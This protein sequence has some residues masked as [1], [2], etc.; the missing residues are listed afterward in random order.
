M[1][2][3]SVR[4]Q[5]LDAAARRVAEGGLEELT[6]DQ[7]AADAGVSK[8]GLLYH[9]PTKADLIEA[10]IR[11]VLRRF[12][13]TVERASAGS[14]APGTWTRAYI[15]ATFDAEVSRPALATALLAS[16]EVGT[17]L[18]RT[19]ARTFA[20][21]QRSLVADGIDAGTAATIRFAC[22]GWWTLSSLTGDGDDDAELLRARLH[23]LADEAVSSRWTG[24]GAR[25]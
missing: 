7:V 17:D 15:D 20:D 8:G 5:L 22:D 2:R 23:E 4:P 18:A 6:L 24:T 11:D 10:L 3:P 9:F 13:D 12:E 1:A 21:W 19:C 14:D 25:P 16:P